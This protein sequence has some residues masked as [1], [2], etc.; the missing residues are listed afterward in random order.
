MN[1]VIFK[2]DKIGYSSQLWCLPLWVGLYQY[3]VM[4]SWFVGLVPV[5]QS[6]GLDLTSLK[7]SAVSSSRFQGV[8]RIDMALGS[9]SASV[10]HCVSILLKHWHGALWALVHADLWVVSVLVLSQRSFGGLLSINVPW[11][12]EFSSGSKSWA[13]HLRSSGSKPTETLSPQKPHSTKYK[14]LI[15]SVKAILSSPEHPEAYTKAL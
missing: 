1:S 4:T 6:M 15:F 3:P 10:Q 9:L 7:G 13:S 12:Q 11:C 5:F 8:C 2:K 14:F